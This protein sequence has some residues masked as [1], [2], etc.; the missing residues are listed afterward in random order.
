MQCWNLRA[1]GVTVT[2]HN[3]SRR[4]CQMPTPM[5]V[6]MPKQTR[7]TAFTQP[8]MEQKQTAYTSIPISQYSL[9]LHLRKDCDAPVVRVRQI[10]KKPE[11]QRQLQSL[12]QIFCLA[13]HTTAATAA[14]TAIALARMRAPSIGCV[15]AFRE[16]EHPISMHEWRPHTS[17]I[18]R[19]GGM[20]V[21][22]APAAISGQ[23]GQQRFCCL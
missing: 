9:M 22:V 4:K 20:V 18:L 6:A 14:T 17:R 2:N 1:G 16:R 21:D 11:V 15:D 8:Q 7:A 19:G 3:T 23:V 13:L 10:R 12:K 5:Q